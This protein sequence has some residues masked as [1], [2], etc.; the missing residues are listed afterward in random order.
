MAFTKLTKLR[1]SLSFHVNTAFQ[2]ENN[3]I[4]GIQRFRELFYTTFRFYIYF[5]NM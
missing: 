4:H 1:N 3:P 2:R 5:D